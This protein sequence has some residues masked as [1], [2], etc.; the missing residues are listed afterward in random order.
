MIDSKRKFGNGLLLPAGPLR[1]GLWRLKTVDMLIFNGEIPIQKDK[2]STGGIPQILMTLAATK[3][4]N[5]KTLQQISLVSFLEKLSETDSR[6]MINALA[7][8]G[9]P[10]RF[11]KTL[12]DI[13]FNLD[14]SV[15]F[16]DHQHYNEEQFAEF[17]DSMPLLMTEKDAVKCTAFAKDNWWYLPVD[18]EI[19]QK[20][21]APLL[22]AILTKLKINKTIN[23]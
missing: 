13:G 11:F 23:N 22:T 16:V 10:S 14:K 4:V 6:K 20:K 5:L 19:E 3:V 21:I 9:D 15:A 2:G 17:S 7:G 12:T 8:I 18:A 1:E